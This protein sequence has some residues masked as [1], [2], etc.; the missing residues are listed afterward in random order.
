MTTITRLNDKQRAL[1]E[2]AAKNEGGSVFPLKDGEVL[3]AG[4]KRSLNVLLKRGLLEERAAPASLEQDEIWREEDDAAYT[5]VLSGMGL[6]AITPDDAPGSEDDTSSTKAA[7]GE[8][9]SS[10]NAT[11]QDQVL[12]L[13][14]REDGASLTEIEE[15]TGW[16]RHSVRGFLSGT[17]KKKL[18]IEVTSEQSEGRGRVYRA[19]GAGA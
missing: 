11:K 8:A 10:R 12:S 13:L 5:L 17:V 9:P 4:L 14:C 19:S 1:L 18:G 3:T 6:Q 16:Q 7:N 15:A 2:A